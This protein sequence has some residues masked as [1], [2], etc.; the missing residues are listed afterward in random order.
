MAYAFDFEWANKNLMFG[1]YARTHSVFQNSD[2]M[3]KGKP[4]P[5][6]LAL[7]TPYRGKV[8][9]EAFAE[10][11]APGERWFRPG[12]PTAAQG[13]R[14]AECGWLDNQGRQARQSKGEP[15]TVEFLVFER[16]SEPH[17]RF[18]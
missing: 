8:P 10:F 12:S 2:M 4:S 15:L 11:G 18:I 3:A 5:E 14:I 7:L 6:E 17:Q 13:R 9:D 16:V 1:A